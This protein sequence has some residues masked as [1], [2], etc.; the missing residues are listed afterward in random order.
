MLWQVGDDE[1]ASTPM[2]KR[3]GT[4]LLGGRHRLHWRLTP[5]HSHNAT[6]C[7]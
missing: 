6:F 7:R 3:K 5:L 1:G 2:S 4:A